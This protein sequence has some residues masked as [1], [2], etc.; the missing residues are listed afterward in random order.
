MARG[1]EVTWHPPYM[2]HR[3]DN[4]VN[5]LNGDWLISRQRYFGV[6]IPVWYRLDGDGYFNAQRHCLYI[7]DVASGAHRCVY[8]KDAM[9]GFTFDW[10]PDSRAIAEGPP[11]AR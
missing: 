3:Y 6:P 8:S 7:I 10:S 4:W 9:G 2:R 5:G 1:D 11:C